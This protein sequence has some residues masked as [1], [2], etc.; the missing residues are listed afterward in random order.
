MAYK[1]SEAAVAQFKTAGYHSPV[2][3]LFTSESA[4]LRARLEAREAAQDGALLPAQRN[5]ANLCYSN[6]LTT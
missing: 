3:V 2:P 5:K 4:D 1:L 6:G